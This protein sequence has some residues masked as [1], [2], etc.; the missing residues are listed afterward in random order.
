M[1]NEFSSISPIK[2]MSSGLDESLVELRCTNPNFR[3][4][5]VSNYIK[6]RAHFFIGKDTK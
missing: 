1:K 5:K 6:M 4:K 3:N 2:I